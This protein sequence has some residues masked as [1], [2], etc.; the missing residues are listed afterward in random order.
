[1]KITSTIMAM[2]VT[3]DVVDKR[4]KEK[5]IE[6]IF[7]YLWRID[8]QFSPYKNESEVSKINEGKISIENCSREM[9]E[10]LEIAGSTK[11]QTNGYFDVWNNAKFDPS[12]IVKG[13]AIWKASQKLLELGYKNFSLEIAGDLQTYGINENG[14]KWRI[15][16]QNP[17]NLS[18][19][20]K[21]VGLSG[22]GIA[23]SGSYQRGAHIYD[24]HTG[25][26]VD[27]ISSISVIGSNVMEADRFATAAFA[28]GEKGIEVIESIAGLEGYMIKKDKTAVMTSGF[29]KYTLLNDKG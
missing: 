25:N 18:E 17:F 21:I 6:I 27:D 23:T 10:V 7:E 3:V 4:A 20:V 8:E 12:G 19:I 9:Q 28:M 22:Q 15:G 11:K 5:D 24:P 14:D 1:M 26:G 13:W 16:I 2:P 29:E